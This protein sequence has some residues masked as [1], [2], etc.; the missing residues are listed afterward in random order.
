MDQTANYQI[1]RDLNV[2]CCF[3]HYLVSS[4]ARTDRLSVTN[5][6]SLI[7]NKIEIYFDGGCW[8]NP[9]DRGCWKCLICDNTKSYEYSGWIYQKDCTNNIA[10]YEGL[11]NSLIKA[12]EL[13]F[14]DIIIYG[15]SQLVVKQINKKWR[16]KK[17]YLKEYAQ[18][19]WK[20]LKNF[21][22][23]SLKWIPREENI[24]ADEIYNE[25][26]QSYLTNI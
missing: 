9:G 3:T 25:N 5:E 11:F 8:P 16:I 7:M 21:D 14:K 6:Y 24:D 15:D 17:D 18:E 20:L 2:K 19:C 12:K 4:Q 10:E 13:N 22:S 26:H 1:F 23:W